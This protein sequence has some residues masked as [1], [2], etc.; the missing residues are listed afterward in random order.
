MDFFLAIG[1]VIRL[2]VGNVCSVRKNILV[3]IEIED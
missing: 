3:I 1:S 2:I